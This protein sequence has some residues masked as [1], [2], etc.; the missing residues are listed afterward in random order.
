MSLAND[1]KQQLQR[2][3]QG[4]VIASRTLHALSNNPQQIDKAV[5][6]LYKTEGLFKLRNGLFY[7]PYQSKFFGDLPPPEKNVIRAL[8]Q[9]Y[10]AAINPSGELAAYQLGLIHTLPDIITYDTD[11]RI[12]RI[13]LNNHILCFNKVEGKKLRGTP[14]LL[15]T[16]LKAG[17]F[18]FK[19]EGKLNS[20][21]EKHLRRL[22]SRFSYAQLNNAL[23]LWPR[24]FQEKIGTLL[25]QS[26]RRYITALSALNIPHDGKQADWHQSGMLNHKKFHI[27]GSNYAS[28]PNVK[29]EELFDCEAFL[30]KFNIELGTTLCA[31]PLRAIKDILFA[32]IIQKTQYPKFFKLD[33]YMLQLPKSTIKQTVRELKS[34]ANKKQ[35]QLL[36]QWE[37]EN[38]LE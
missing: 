10:N 36:E 38:E 19:Q 11:K 30:S 26:E 23:R 7:R 18:I 29:D 9:Q 5:S 25:N 37:F 24:W 4:G 17:E 14:Q 13:Q 21:Q 15:L 1:V 35:K 28:A 27:A 34:L 6:R 2:V 22:L 33:Q 8:K 3:P 20:R 31:T 16:I 32:S 12:G